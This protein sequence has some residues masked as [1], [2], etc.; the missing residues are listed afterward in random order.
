[1][2]AA[3]GTA[4]ATA[5]FNPQSNFITSPSQ[6]PGLGLWIDAADSNTVGLTGGSNVISVR[7]KSSNGY[8]FSNAVGFTYNVTKFNGTYPSFFTAT[9]TAGFNLGINTSAAFTQPLT[10]F[11]VGVVSGGGYIFD[12]T[13]T[14]NRIAIFGGGTLFAGTQVNGTA[15]LSANYVLTAL[16]NTGN[17][18]FG[19]VYGSNYLTGVA[20][21]G[22]TLAT[23]VL[24][25]S[26]FNLNTEVYVG[27]F[28][29]LIFYRGILTTTQ[30]QQVEGYLAWKW[31]LANNFPQSHP[32]KFASN[33][34]GYIASFPAVAQAG[35]SQFSNFITSPTQ[36][37]G[38]QLWLDSSDQT[39]VVL[40]NTSNVTQWNDKRSNGI[41]F[42]AV[43]T[44]SPAYVANAKNGLPS[45][46]FN[47]TSQQLANTTF[48]FPNTAFTVY[49]VHYQA[50]SLGTGRVLTGNTDSRLFVG[51]QGN[52]VAVFTGAPPWNDTNALTP[53][54]TGLLQW[55]IISFTVS[56]STLTPFIDGT[57]YN[58]KT[59]TTGTFTGLNIGSFAPANGTQAW[60]GYISEILIYSNALTATQRQQVEGYLAWKWGLQRS[61]PVS[62]Y[63]QNS[64]VT[65]IAAPLPLVTQPAFKPWVFSPTSLPGLALWLDAADSSVQTSGNIVT[66]WIDKSGSNNNAQAS[67][68]PTLVQNALNGLPVIQFSSNTQQFF[69]CGP[70]AVRVVSSATAVFALVNTTN[71]SLGMGIITKGFTNGGN[72]DRGWWLLT[73]TYSIR[74]F[75]TY[76][77]ALFTIGSNNWFIISGMG[78][79]TGS[80]FPAYVNG[81][82]SGFNAFT[83]AQTADNTS[84]CFV[85][86]SEVGSYF[87]GYIA[88]IICYNNI[89]TLTDSLRTQMEGYLAWKWGL[90]DRLP[91]THPNKFV[92][93]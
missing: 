11:V 49:T 20:V 73:N 59:G 64:N 65:G 76:N 10:V 26:R 44:T 45:I 70:N 87:N 77:L 52:N 31:G 15:N 57:G 88:E 86:R 13:N 18:S 89:T 63:Q 43:G 60:N 8:L 25:G 28:C 75:N 61:L 46:S 39:S 69:S 24:L 6:I 78:Y 23:G 84:N 35:L 72:A 1:M 81:S 62:H 85:G 12:G 56:G 33:N 21:G 51:V 66:L 41:S 42:M 32:F 54:I 36:I 58:T 9:Q 14:T 91:F 48:V 3:T 4:A 5:W 68:S 93:P 40:S 80:L 7:D 90:T 92:V 22:N 30:R 27:H 16:F 83:H 50:G 37:A 53:F 71:P 38:L 47:G 19:A 67:N 82:L 34:P 74:N 55:R 29:E 79:R 2:S 17:S